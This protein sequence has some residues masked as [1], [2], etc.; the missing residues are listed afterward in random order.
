MKGYGRVYERAMSRNLVMTHVSEINDPTY[1]SDKIN[2]SYI[3]FGVVQTFVYM[4]WKTG[5]GNK[6][7]DMIENHERLN[8]QLTSASSD[9]TNKAV[10]PPCNQC[11]KVLVLKICTLKNLD[12]LLSMR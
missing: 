11:V 10:P 12:P 6:E 5:T 3:I 9:D 2:R 8:I 4:E 1:L 7:H